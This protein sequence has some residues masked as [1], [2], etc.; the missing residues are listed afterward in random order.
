L[1]TVVRIQLD[2]LAALLF[3][4]ADR[5]LHE[6]SA[7]T[8]LSTIGL[9]KKIFESRFRCIEPQGEP[10]ALLDEAE[11]FS[12]VVSSQ[13]ELCIAARYHALDTRSEGLLVRIAPLH[14]VP[15]VD[16]QR[17][18]GF[19]VSRTGNADVRILYHL[20][21]LH[22]GIGEAGRTRDKIRTASRSIP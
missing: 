20:T 6:P 1:I 14:H 16:D 4:P 21:R 5:E 12:I 7:D 13:E 18:Q 22:F 2:G 19:E 15:P 9:Y 3:S 17:Q 8:H 10:T 11:S